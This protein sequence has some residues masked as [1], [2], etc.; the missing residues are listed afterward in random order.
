MKSVI[1]GSAAKAGM[2]WLA[3]RYTADKNAYTEPEGW[4]TV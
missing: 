4:L 1:H 3:V 2:Q